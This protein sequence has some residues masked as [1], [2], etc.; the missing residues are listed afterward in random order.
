MRGD[1]RQQEE[2]FSYGSLSERIPREHPLRRL[3]VMT[4]EA[5][6]ELEPVLDGLYGKTGRPSIPPEQLLRAL[7]LQMLYSVRSERMLVEQID[8]SILFRW[9]IGLSLNDPV[10]DATSFTK[11][12]DRLLSGAVARQFFQ[13]VLGQARRAR[14]LHDERF[15]VDG[16]L[17]DAWASEK[18]YQKKPGP[19]PSKGSGS[20]GEVLKRDTHQSMTDPEAQLYRKGNK[21]G[22]GLRHMA[23]AVSENRHGLV[24]ETAVSGCSPKH[25]RVQA[26]Q[27]IGRLRRTCRPTVVVADKSYHE[28]DFVEGLASM[29]IAAH[30]PPYPEGRRRCWVD[31]SLYATTDYV[32]SQKRRKWIERF[33]AWLKTTAGLRKTRHRGHRKLDWNFTF[34]AAYNLTRL[35]TLLPAS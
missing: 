9:F 12:R 15:T 19:P 2:M 4:D 5:L 32:E 23:H 14:L 3:R 26:L 33:F 6:S 21:L 22:L 7:L 25:E 28:Q 17:I 20:E 29:G 30:V 34:A 8:F 31:R 16:T 10:W 24:V 18:S 1:D 35:A 11:N 27:M 13:A